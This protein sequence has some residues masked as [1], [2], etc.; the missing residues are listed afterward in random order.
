[1]TDIARLSFGGAGRPEGQG[2]LILSDDGT[3]RVEPGDALRDALAHREEIG[4]AQARSFGTLPGLGLIAAGLC[5]IAVGWYA[6]RYFGK[7]A[8]RRTAARSVRVVE[9]TSEGS[10]LRARLGRSLWDI[11]DFDHS[12]AE[13][14]LAALEEMKHEA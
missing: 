9:V 4:L 5:A 3:V 7:Y 14:F 1:V 13:T 8:W 6:G 10:H 2:A 12:E 11:T